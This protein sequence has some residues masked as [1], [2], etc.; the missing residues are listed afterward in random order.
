MCE[1][2]LRDIE[3]APARISD[4][5][6][7]C[8]ERYAWPGNVRELRAEMARWAVV[9]GPGL[10]VGPE[11]LSAAIRTAGGFSAER[12]G[13]TQE[14]SA[15]SGDG[16]LEAAIEELERALLTRGLERTGGNRTRL[17]KELVI[18]RTTLNE[19]LKRY[20]LG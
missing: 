7:S 2:F 19:R 17:A 11:H 10:E 8:L 18:S 9:S 14:T 3:N 1:H 13:G 12:I 20:G 16:S 5:A 15:A 4:G 6:W